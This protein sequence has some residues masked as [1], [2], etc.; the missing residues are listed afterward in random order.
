MKDQADLYN[1]PDE[2]PDGNPKHVEQGICDTARRII[3][4]ARQYAYVRADEDLWNFAPHY[5][6]PPDDRRWCI[7]MQAGGSASGVAK[8]TLLVHTTHAESTNNYWKDEMKSDLNKEATEQF[9]LSNCVHSPVYRVM[10]WYSN[11]FHFFTGFV[12]ASI[13]RGGDSQ[14]DKY[15]GGEH[16]MWLV[17]AHSPFLSDRESLTGVGMIDQFFDDWLPIFVHQ[18]RRLGTLDYYL[19]KKVKQDGTLYHGHEARSL[20]STWADLQYQECANENGLSKPDTRIGR[21]KYIA[22]ENGEPI[23]DKHTGKPQRMD[24]VTIQEEQCKREGIGIFNAYVELHK[25]I[26]DGDHADEKKTRL[27]ERTKKREQHKRQQ[28]NP[29]DAEYGEEYNRHR[30]KVERIPASTETLEKLNVMESELSL[31]ESKEE[32]LVAVETEITLRESSSAP[33]AVIAE[34]PS[35]PEAA[36]PAAIVETPSPPEAAPPAVIVETPIV[37][38]PMVEYDAEGGQL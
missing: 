37:E 3:S 15:L 7:G 20:A 31:R 30:T 35:P 22:Y 4:R 26:L 23:I 32:A 11:P 12:E 1:E 19:N 28:E 34:T 2:Y 29:A 24:K 5:P 9:I 13:S 36:P 21:R 14:P 6:L 27:K 10:L 8:F 18:A 38:T 33:P 25:K 16:P 17:S